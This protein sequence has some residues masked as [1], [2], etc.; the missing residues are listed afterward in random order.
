MRAGGFPRPFFFGT[1]LPVYRFIA[2][3]G[4]HKRNDRTKIETE[5]MTGNPL[6]NA[7]ALACLALALASAGQAQ[8]IPTCEDE[9]VLRVAS[10]AVTDAHAKANFARLGT[11]NKVIAA[12][13][14]TLSYEPAFAVQ[15]RNLNTAALSQHGPEQLDAG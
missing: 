2:M 8:E 3:T 9:E 1:T 4:Q 15:P 14:F 7:L 5:F 6:R 12:L 10:E 13:G 11:A